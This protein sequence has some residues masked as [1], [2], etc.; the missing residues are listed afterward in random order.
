M[1]LIIHSKQTMQLHFT[2]DIKNILLL[3]LNCCKSYETRVKISVKK[4]A[5]QSSGHQ[6]YITPGDISVLLKKKGASREE[7]SGGIWALLTIAPS[8]CD[9]I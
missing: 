2:E 1:N 5:S 6:R 7:V 9:P 4:Q 8:W 3:I